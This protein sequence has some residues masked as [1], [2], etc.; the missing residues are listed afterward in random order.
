MTLKIGWFSSG[1]DKAARD[2]LRAVRNAIKSGEIEAEIS[3][4]FCSREYGESEESDRFLNL[5]KSYHLPLKTL[6]YQKFKGERSGLRLGHH[7]APW[8][9]DYD[10]EVIRE[11]GSFEF[12]IG[13]LA[14]YMLIMSEELCLRY[15]L[16]NLHP[17]IPGGPVGTWEEV[18]WQ[19]IEERAEKAGAMMHLVTPQLD[20][21]PALTYFAFPL[22]GQPFEKYWL[23]LK[24]KEGIDMR[25][26]PAAQRLFNTIR[27]YELA[28]EFPLVIATLKAL[29]S[30]LIKLD[31]KPLTPYDLS[32][33][34]EEK[35]DARYRLSYE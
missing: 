11:I 34:V 7:L 8:R 2:L 3:F 21:G 13:V 10:K 26:L 29:G 23:R 17:S 4:V 30:G 25:Q 12:D 5:A 32:Q 6:S 18:I 15:R 19:L 22:T 14:G 9:L 33:E 1:R 27:R 31:Y 20:G 16:I 24:G 28:R 35:V